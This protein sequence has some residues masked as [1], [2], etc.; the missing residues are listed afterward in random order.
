MKNK[1][2]SSPMLIALFGMDSRSSKNMEMYFKG[3]C[4]GIAAVVG[5][6]NAEIDMID[7]DY[8]QAFEILQNRK[9]LEPKR[10]IILLSIK[11]LNVEDTFFIQKPVTVAQITTTLNQIQASHSI[12]AHAKPEPQPE[13]PAVTASEPAVTAAT[14]AG[15]PVAAPARKPAMF[16]EVFGNKKNEHRIPAAAQAPAQ[17]AHRTAE[18]LNEGGFITFLG[19]PGNIDFN[20]PKQWQTAVFDRNQYLVGYVLSAWQ[21][22]L[23]QN[24]VLQLNSMW[25]PILVF[26]ETGSVWLDSNEKQ[27]LAFAGLKLGQEQTGKINLTFLPPDVANRS[28]PAEHFHDIQAF[29]WKLALWASKGRRPEE[30]DLNQ[31]LTL[32]QWPN[33]TRLVITPDALRIA[34]LLTKEARTPLEDIK[35]LNCKPQ[36]LFV[37]LSACQALNL[38]AFQAVPPAAAA[39]AKSTQPTQVK[40]SILGKILSKLR[41]K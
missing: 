19:S 6:Q 8:R 22:A 35:T 5:E 34:A 2:V 17:P 15:K 31:P 32:K 25:K 1:P 24:Q 14:H 27:L 29:L 36:H 13:L 21:T 28:Y 30:I 26:P 9:A 37:F 10:P 41:G 18:E 11:S 39:S 38:L 20:D 7:A 23:V 33:F 4:G 3:P 40:S 12:K 16:M